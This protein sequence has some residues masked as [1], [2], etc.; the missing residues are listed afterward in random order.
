MTVPDIEIAEPNT[1]VP[2]K[3]SSTAL[4]VVRFRKSLAFKNT[5]NNIRRTMNEVPD[6]GSIPVSPMTLTAIAPSKNVVEIRTIANTKAAAIEKPPIAKII[7]LDRSGIYM[8]N[9]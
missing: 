3:P 8:K 1:V 5:P 7:G 4:S 2:T 9:G 6:T